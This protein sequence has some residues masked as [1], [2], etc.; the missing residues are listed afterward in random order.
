M[1]N[2]SY[3][4]TGRAVSKLQ[5]MLNKVKAR[6]KLKVDGIFGPLTRKAVLDFQKRHKDLADDGVAGSRTMKR[7]GEAAKGGGA[8]KEDPKAAATIRELEQFHA[9]IQKAEKQSA[10]ER[11]RYR[12]ACIKTSKVIAEQRKLLEAALSSA[13][14]SM[15]WFVEEMT[16]GAKREG[17]ELKKVKASLAALMKAKD[18]QAHFARHKAELMRCLDAVDQ[19]HMVIADWKVAMHSL[20]KLLAGLKQA[21]AAIEKAADGK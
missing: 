13:D 20:H 9:K 4:S 7:L 11:K 5:T 16:Q 19:H 3:G 1:A 21:G 12:A 15:G 18:K 2:L 6:P 14:R 17:I 8:P 10:E